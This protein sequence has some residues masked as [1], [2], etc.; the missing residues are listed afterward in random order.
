MYVFTNILQERII[1]SRDPDG[2]LR[3]ATWEEREKMNAIYF[4]SPGK[5]FIV[6]KMFTDPEAFQSIL[7]RAIQ[8][9]KE[10]RNTCNNLLCKQLF[11]RSITNC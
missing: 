4:P 10:G 3:Y 5:E 9:I 2:T 7:D 6:P 11:C 1:V 8:L